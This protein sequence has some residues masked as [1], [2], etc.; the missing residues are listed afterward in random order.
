MQY[1][2]FY[3]KHKHGLWQGQ[4][5][6]DVCSWLWRPTLC[7]VD[8]MHTWLVQKHI[9]IRD[10]VLFTR[11][12]RNTHICHR[13]HHNRPMVW[14]GQRKGDF[15]NSKKQGSLSE[16]GREWSILLTTFNNNNIRMKIY[17]I[18]RMCTFSTYIRELF[19]N[20][21]VICITIETGS[22][23]NKHYIPIHQ[24]S[25]IENTASTAYTIHNL[26]WVYIHDTRL[27]RD[28]LIR[29]SHCS[30]TNCVQKQIVSFFVLNL[31]IKRV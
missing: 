9:N 5:T 20:G 6:N 19:K 14:I 28:L 24:A 7:F 10:C 17:L 26:C 8:Q 22:V 2:W 16:L 25:F 18:I 15:I 31:L 12:E 27:P 29:F 1:L 4:L 30:K 23:D 3:E 13:L 11:S 21:L